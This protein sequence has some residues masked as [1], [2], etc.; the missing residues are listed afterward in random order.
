M[1]YDDYGGLI[2]ILKHLFMLIRFCLINLRLPMNLYIIVFN[3]C[4][5]AYMLIGSLAHS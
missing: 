2:Y 4:M 1:F 5:H 3:G